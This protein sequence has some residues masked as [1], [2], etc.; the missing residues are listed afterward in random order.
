MAWKL[1]SSKPIYIQLIEVLETRIV[2]GEYQPGQKVPSVRELAG[3]AG[4]NPNT[5]QKALVELE[6]KG[7]IV[8]NRTSGRYVTENREI[9]DSVKESNV[10]EFVKEFIKGMIALGFTKSEI[11][12][13]VSNHLEK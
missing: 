9:L 10:D 3:E 2:S 4:V 6:N 11:K 8:T 5:M 13:I 12:D 1:D 7:M